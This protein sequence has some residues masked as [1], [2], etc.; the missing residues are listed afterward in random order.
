MSCAASFLTK[1]ALAT[2]LSFVAFAAHAQQ[3]AAPYTHATRYNA[4]GQ[5]TGTIAPDP[6]GSGILAFRATRHTYGT[7]GQ[8]IGLLV[9]VEMGELAS[10]A[11]E[12]VAP[13]SWESYGFAPY[14]TKTLD[15]DNRGRKVAER[16]IGADLVTESLTQYSYDDWDRV[17]C[18]A[19]R[20]NMTTF[21]SPPSDACA[22]GTEGTVGPDR[23]TRFT[24]N[25]FDQVLT[26][27]R[28][29][30]T[31][32]A[33]TYVT[34][35]Y[36]LD[37]RLLRYQI[38]AKGNK[39]ELQ[40]DEHKRL[41]K[42]LYPSP[43]STGSVNASDYNEYDYDNNGNVFYERK[44]NGQTINYSIDANNRVTFKNLS[45]NTYSA[46]TTY[47][48]DLRGLTLSS[49]FGTADDCVS[50]GSGET[51][52]F[53]GFG[54]FDTRTSRM[55]GVNRALTF[56]YD[57]DSNQTRI[58]H[59]DGNAFSYGFD[60][61]NRLCTVT[62]GLSATPCDSAGYMLK[63]TYR[64]SGGRLDLIRPSGAVTNID[65]DSALRLESFTQNFAGTAN[66][67]T[68]GF[69][70]NPSN[71]ITKL[72]QSNSLYTYDQHGSRVG[73]YGSN[74][75][76]QITSIAGNSLSH[77]VAGNVTNDGAGMTYTYDMENHLVA[78]GGSTSSTLIYDVLG[79]LVQIAV[80]GTTTQFHYDGDALVGEYVSGSLTRR[81]A[82]GDQVDEPL[83]Q[84]NGASV[85]ASFRRYLHADHQGSI[86]AHSDSAGAV[87]QTNS[88]DPYGI[89]KSTN[90]GR[91]GYTGQTW[92]PQLGL[93][94]YKARI[95]APRLGRF[96][97]TDPIFYADNF[98]LYGYAGNDPIGRR[99]PSGLASDWIDKSGSNDHE[100]RYQAR[101][102]HGTAID[103]SADE[104][105]VHTQERL[106]SIHK[107]AN[108]GLQAIGNGI[109]AV[110]EAEMLGRGAKLA[111]SLGL[112]LIVR[113]VGGSRALR[114]SDLGIEGQVALLR[115]RIALKGDVV[116]I[117][118]DMIQVAQDK[119]LDAFQ[120]F[121]NMKNLAIGA[122]AKTLRIEGHVGNDRLDALL[123]TRFGMATE[124]GVDVITIPLK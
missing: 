80:G 108:D 69:W 40:Y 119:T 106:R 20:M 52:T 116:T 34:N 115:G 29:V 65:L 51:N 70:Y 123:R 14:L 9:K 78:T 120:I 17:R 6:D 25:S 26:E 56:A 75:L 98:N 118:V 38:D 33:Q 86:I 114:S 19:V 63:V 92:L 83:L 11:N 27:E 66:D 13:S 84:Y 113:T 24:Y 103:S 76:N 10:W 36:E 58:T 107:M 73:S 71:Q 54:E 81:Y 32:L 89:P 53:T 37:S 8:T 28:A 88:Y 117:R 94:Y 15:Y 68:N 102:A 61:L 50:T 64:P 41:W 91:F 3:P 72:A 95:Y 110:A 44:R 97:Q 101:V 49:C 4:A 122:G 21:G 79:R 30:G 99:D 105:D 111:G 2:L 82:H 100:K 23:I 18:K 93:N 96:M 59:P 124:S 85:G 109:E 112:G 12:N 48:Y 55:S 90:D 77:D 57:R 39:T 7:S 35:Q 22:L 42:R 87:L 62:E 121:S 60:G 104:A 45:D 46:D 16:V 67:L 47:N 31:S 5:V 74:G 43:T 1:G